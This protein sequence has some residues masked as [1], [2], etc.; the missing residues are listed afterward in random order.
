[1]N[2]SANS[3]ARFKATRITWPITLVVPIAAVLVLLAFFMTLELPGYVHGPGVPRLTVLVVLLSYAC[4][5]IIWLLAETK[6]VSLAIP[7]IQQPITWF[8]RQI[9]RLPLFIFLFI[10]LGYSLRLLGFFI[11]G[12]EPRITLHVYFG[13]ATYEALKAT[14]IYCS[15]LG[16][17]FGVLSFASMQEQAERLLSTQKTLAEAKLLNL[18]GQLRPHFLF[19]ALNIISALM[20]IDVSRADR[21]L[22]QLGDLLRANLDASE[23]STVPLREEL[24]LL[25]LYAAI[26]EE[27][28]G[29]RIA[30][31]WD[32]D[33]DSTDALVPAMLLQP[34]LENAFK[35]GVE[36]SL[37]LVRIS[38]STERGSNSLRI[39]IRNSDSILAHKPTKGLGLRNCRERLMLL[40]GSAGTLT[41]TELDG[42]VAVVTIPWTVK[43]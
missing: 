17:A 3:S 13:L 9:K 30:V 7:S 4:T 23:S 19:N 18:Q 32:I 1:M 25:R 41:L 12:F 36:P 39:S 40:Y 27:R 43:G 15:W 38:V 6:S 22:T 34:L 10:A 20:Q 29:D 11:V 14:L 26:M 8:L 28:F 35:H 2:N 37:G 42:V 24:Q 31:T 16:L 5:V 21:T 33:P